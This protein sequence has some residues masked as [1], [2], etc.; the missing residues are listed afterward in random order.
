MFNNFFV[1]HAM[2]L[3]T[4]SFCAGSIYCV[5]G[6]KKT[7]LRALG[8][9]PV[10]ANHNAEI[11]ADRLPP[12]P[13][14]FKVNYAYHLPHHLDS[15]KA[16]ISGVYPILDKI[17]ATA[18]YY[19]NKTF[20]ITGADGTL[21]RAMIDYI[22]PNFKQA[23]VIALTTN[24][25]STIADDYKSKR[26]RVVHFS[27]DNYDELESVLSKS[28]ILIMNHAVKPELFNGEILNHAF[29]INVKSYVELAQA[30]FKT[31]KTH[32]DV[33]LKEVWAITSTAEVQSLNRRYFAYE[34]SKRQLGEVISLLRMSSP[35]IVRKIILKGFKSS[36]SPEAKTTA[37]HLIPKI[38][39]F[40][41]RDRRNIVIANPLINLLVIMKEIFFYWNHK[42]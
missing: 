40:A 12:K 13:N 20:A 22:L 7:I 23:K 29:R 4:I 18:R 2:E 30:F 5:D 11:Y 41:K 32:K 1:N 38:F 37:Q 8:L 6:I 25:Q 21:G 19:D 42:S 16:Y 39:W 28:H 35:C 26:L 17:L 34:S 15:G 24:F 9:T 31:V 10:D 36:M 14:Q 33:A 3:I 27:V